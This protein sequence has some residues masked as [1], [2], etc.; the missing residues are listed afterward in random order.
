MK[1]CGFP[2]VLWYNNLVGKGFTFSTAVPIKTWKALLAGWYPADENILSGTS[3]LP[4]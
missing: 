2:P 1:T 3:P 4:Y